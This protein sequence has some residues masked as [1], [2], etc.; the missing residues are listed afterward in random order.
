MEAAAESIP[1]R[2]HRLV[3]LKNHTLSDLME[4]P[5]VSYNRCESTL[6]KWHGLQ[7]FKIRKEALDGEHSMI[8]KSTHFE[9]CK[10]L[11]LGLIHQTAGVQKND[12]SITEVQESTY[13]RWS[14]TLNILQAHIHAPHIW[15]LS[16]RLTVNK[17]MSHKTISTWW[18]TPPTTNN[19][20]HI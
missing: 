7:L 9:T 18:T 3:L 8:I 14:D 11:C 19:Q 4:W 5:A 20:Y 17:T 6:I 2:L 10:W 12:T 15:W 16:S 13:F 1:Y